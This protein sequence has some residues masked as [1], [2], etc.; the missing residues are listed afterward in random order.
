M[1]D[2]DKLAA[3]FATQ[4]PPAYDAGFVAASLAAFQRRQTIHDLSLVAL[5]GVVTLLI[6]VLIG[7]R[8]SIPLN[9]IMPALA[10]VVLVATTL[11][12]TGRMPGLRA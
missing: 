4:E 1:T 2:D 10:P 8:V 5:V 7:G 12:L 3:F 6:A 9:A 11:Y